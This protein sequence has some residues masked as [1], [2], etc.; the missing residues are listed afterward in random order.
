M[1]G[2]DRD[3]GKTI[4]DIDHIRQSVAD[5]LTTS[6]GT[7]VMRRDYGSLLPRLVDQPLN[8]ATLLRAYSASV[9]AIARWEPRIRIRRIRRNVSATVPGEARLAIDAITPSGEEAEIAVAIEGRG[10]V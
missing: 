6:V 8:E 10:H 9:A 1:Q 2:M 7:R 5:I 4:G 3:T